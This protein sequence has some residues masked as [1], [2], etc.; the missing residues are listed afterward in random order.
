[1]LRRGD[2][3]LN[4]IMKVIFVTIAVISF[5]IGGFF[6]WISLNH[7]PDPMFNIGNGF[8]ES[9]TVYFEGKK[10]GKIEPRESKIFYPGEIL[11]TDN[12]DLLLE[13]KSN[14]GVAL[15]SKLYTSDAL[16]VVLESVKGKPYW[17]GD[18][19]FFEIYLTDTGELVLSDREILAYYGAENAFA[20]NEKGISKWNSYQTYPDIP[21]LSQS[22][23]QRDFIIKLNGKEICR[24]KFYSMASSASYSG[25]AIIDSLF[26]ADS[27]HDKLWLISDYPSSTL[28]NEYSD[29][30]SKL[31]NV[32]DNHSMLR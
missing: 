28:G 7:H 3:K 30:N 1:M 17:I 2:S 15:F 21:K 22:L 12:S 9:V 4:K 23:Y 6:A 8:D 19:I 24:G 18:T 11:T 20:L 29:I 31:K 26:K 32:F 27:A 16:D 14:S 5:A 25:I 10:M 13:L